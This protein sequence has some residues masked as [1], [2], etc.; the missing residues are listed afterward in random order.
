MKIDKL[1][2]LFRSLNESHRNLTTKPKRIE[3]QAQP[4]SSEAVR[5]A[6][7]FGRV[8]E[9]SEV[10]RDARVREIKNAVSEGRYRPDTKAVAEAVAR[11]LL[12]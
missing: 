4:A 8:P 5:V 3:E 1:A 6:G 7:D 9:S 10:D 12:F 11:E 2:E